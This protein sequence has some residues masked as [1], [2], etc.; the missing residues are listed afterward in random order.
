MNKYIK[1][2]KENEK[3]RQLKNEIKMK[4]KLYITRINYIKII[5]S[6]YLEKR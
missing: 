6:N 4:L 3:K 1:N 5:T 2:G